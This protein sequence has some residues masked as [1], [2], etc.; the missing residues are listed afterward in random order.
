MIREL[1]E[2]V[3]V[4]LPNFCFGYPFVMAWY[5]MAGGVVFYLTRERDD[6][7]AM[8]AA[9]EA[10][11]AGLLDQPRQIDTLSLFVEPARGA[12]FTLHHMVSLAGNETR[13]TA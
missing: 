8:R 2:F 9:I 3:L 11:F 6:Q 1:I 10:Y 7:A 12:P 4:A 13:K 5:W